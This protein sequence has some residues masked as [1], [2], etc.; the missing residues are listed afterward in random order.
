MF[1]GDRHTGVKDPVIRRCGEGWQAWICC[2][3]LDEPGEEDRMTTAYST[4]ADGVTWNWHGTVLAGHLGSWDARGARVTAMLPDGRA[5]YDGRAGKEENFHERTGLA[6]Q[7]GPSGRLTALGD[8]PVSSARYLDVVCLP[9]G[10]YRLFYEA[11]LPDGSHELRTE[12]SSPNSPIIQRHCHRPWGRRTMTSDRCGCL[13][14]WRRA[15]SQSNR[16]PAGLAGLALV[17]RR[18][19]RTS[20]VA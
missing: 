14:G 15:D 16:R 6:C 7:D 8:E 20:G 2:H 17:A 5:S 4:S 9:D 11:P 12:S 13:S 3:P 19:P 10:G 18:R 1:G